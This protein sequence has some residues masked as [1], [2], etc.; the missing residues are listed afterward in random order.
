MMVLASSSAFLLYLSV[1]GLC[2]VKFVPG[3]LL[4]V[5]LQFSFLAQL[6]VTLSGGATGVTVFTLFGER[7]RVL[8][9]QRRMKRRLANGLPAEAEEKPESRMQAFA[10]K[11]WERYGLIGAA[12][13]TP[14][15]FS[16]PIGVAIALSFG[17]PRQKIMPY[18]LASMVVW[19]I[20]FALFGEVLKDF[21][22]DYG[23]LDPPEQPTAPF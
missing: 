17:A 14:P 15:I 12:L 8:V 7:I 5:G 16:P 21:L 20:I 19:S 6:V 9:Q 10:R 2:A 23:I 4:G 1:F 18:Y 13:L 11:V 3:A 22:V